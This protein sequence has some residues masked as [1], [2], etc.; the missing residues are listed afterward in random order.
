M[1]H[2]EMEQLWR[3]MAQKRKTTAGSSTNQKKLRLAEADQPMR[4]DKIVAAPVQA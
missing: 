2:E 1:K 3:N 4:I